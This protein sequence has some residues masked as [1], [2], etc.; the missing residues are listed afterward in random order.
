MDVN[1]S[2]LNLSLCS[3]Q[4]VKIDFNQ[5]KSFFLKTSYSV[6]KERFNRVKKSQEGQSRIWIK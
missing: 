3:V 2:E 1:G 5:I 6:Q 4:V